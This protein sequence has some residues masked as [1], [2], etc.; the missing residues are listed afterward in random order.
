MLELSRYGNI[1]ICNLEEADV[2]Y[3]IDIAYARRLQQEHVVLWWSR[4]PQPDH[5]GYEKDSIL[6]QLEESACRL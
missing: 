5:A 6:R 4:G 3:L 2:R 1:P